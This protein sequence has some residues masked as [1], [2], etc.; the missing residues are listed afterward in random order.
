ML[1][2]ALKDK[3]PEQLFQLISEYGIERGK[4]SDLYFIVGYR[5]N[6]DKTGSEVQKQ[7]VVGEEEDLSMYNGKM[8]F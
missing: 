8:S 1:F 5:A 6:G 7:E 2:M 3:V 4:T